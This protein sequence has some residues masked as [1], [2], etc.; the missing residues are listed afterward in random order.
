VQGTLRDRPTRTQQRFTV[1][2][3]P[4]PVPVRP[5]SVPNERFSRNPAGSGGF[6]D[7]T[8]TSLEI[9]QTQL[10]RIQRDAKQCQTDTTQLDRPLPCCLA[11]PAAQDPAQI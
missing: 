10:K 8:T 9:A 3:R 1:L 2:R 4:F 11:S 6:R 7:P 5:R